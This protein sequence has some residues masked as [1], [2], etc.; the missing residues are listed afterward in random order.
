MEF[1]P[2]AELCLADHVPL[3][4]DHAPAPQSVAQDDKQQ[5]ACMRAGVVVVWWW[6]EKGRGHEIR[7][8]YGLKP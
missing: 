6:G 1:L 5:D 2:L 7:E 3:L 4:V 8:E